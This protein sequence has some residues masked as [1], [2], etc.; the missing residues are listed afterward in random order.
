MSDEE[1]DY[2]NAQAEA[3]ALVSQWVDNHAKAHVKYVRVREQ[4]TTANK[5]I[6]VLKLKMQLDKAQKRV[7]ADFWGQSCARSVLKNRRLRELAEYII[8]H[9]ADT[10]NAG[11]VLVNA[12]PAMIREK[13]KQALKDIK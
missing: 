3:D 1:A 12:S 9:T 4:L 7:A 6:E 2:M 5:E 8:R 11:I 10:C 13:A